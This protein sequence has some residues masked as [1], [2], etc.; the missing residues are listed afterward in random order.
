MI[1]AC[2]DEIEK[3]TLRECLAAWEAE[4]LPWDRY[5]LL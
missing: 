5:C 1:I 3:Q 2:V 4:V